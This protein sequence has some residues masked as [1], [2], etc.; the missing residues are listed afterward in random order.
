MH[1]LM[2]GRDTKYVVYHSTFYISPSNAILLFGG[3]NHRYN[4]DGSRLLFVNDMTAYDIEYAVTL[5]YIIQ[6]SKDTPCARSQAYCWI[7]H[8]KLFTYGGSTAAEKG[9]TLNDLYFLD[10]K[11]YTGIM[12]PSRKNSNIQNWYG[13]DI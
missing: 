6:W 3:F 8:D 10:L 12:P 1:I 9:K 4:H 2:Q 7:I 5:E 13:W 11:A